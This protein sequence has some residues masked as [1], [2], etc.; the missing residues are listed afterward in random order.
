MR[1]MLVRSSRWGENFEEWGQADL[2]EFKEP[3]GF[4][5]FSFVLGVGMAA[6]GL[7][8]PLLCLSRDVAVE[9]RIPKPHTRSPKQALSGCGGVFCP[10]PSLLSLFK[11]VPISFWPWVT[12]WS[13]LNEKYILVSGPS[14]HLQVPCTPAHICHLVLC[15]PGLCKHRPLNECNFQNSSKHIHFWFIP[16]LGPK[17]AAQFCDGFSSLWLQPINQ[18]PFSWG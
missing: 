11:W 1:S 9:L 7:L 13:G 5:L 15:C 17:Q 3:W 8:E 14:C 16:R 6:A 10:S 12:S 4:F 2:E 18:S